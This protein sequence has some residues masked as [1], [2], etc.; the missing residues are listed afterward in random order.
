MLAYGR[1]L[2]WYLRTGRVFIFI[3]SVCG[4]SVIVYSLFRTRGMDEADAGFFMLKIFLFMLVGG[5]VSGRYHEPVRIAA[6][7]GGVTGMVIGLIMAFARFASLP[8][9][10]TLFNLV[11]E[12]VI[13]GV[14]GYLLAGLGGIATHHRRSPAVP[15]S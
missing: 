9:A 11:T 1:D 6:L 5:K 14:F 13:T 4:I 3:A 7:T 2:A 10:W 8:Q 15:V 12:P